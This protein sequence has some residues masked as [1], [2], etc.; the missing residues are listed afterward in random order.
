[1]KRSCKDRDAGGSWWV[2]ERGVNVEADTAYGTATSLQNT[3]R[4]G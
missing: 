2:G 3:R 1:M 4:T